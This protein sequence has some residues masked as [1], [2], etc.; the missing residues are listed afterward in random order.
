MA[1]LAPEAN[2]DLVGQERAA[3][4]LLQ[5]LRSN[6]LPHGWLLAGPRGVG[7]ATLAYRF[8]R[9][10]LRP[11]D[12][13]LDTL[14]LAP[15]HPLFRQ[16]AQRAHPDLKVIEPPRDARTGRLRSEIGVDA[17]RS[18]TASLHTTAAQ[19]GRR[20]VIVDGA[21]ALNRNAANALLKPLEEPP[22]GAVMLLITQ[23]SGRVAPT[24][25]SRVATL[26]LARLDAP[27]LAR[28]LARQAPGLDEPR[29]AALTALAQGSAGTALELAAGPALDL[30]AELLTALA[31][32]E[33]DRLVLHDLVQRLAAHADRSGFGAAVELLQIL[34]QRV[35]ASATGRLGP[36]IFDCEAALLGHLAARRPLDRWAGL[37]EKVGR[38]VGRTES[39]NL[40]RTHVLLLVLAEIASLRP[41]ADR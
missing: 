2:P 14:D 37:W 3:G 22:Q 38:L 11:D 29:R 33:V 20:V 27:A 35:V 18:V 6:R 16:V 25:R 23:D 21:E 17:I 12:P 9:R 7:K 41:P 28:I 31:C 1:I 34:L 19:G 30:Y 40:D 39:L 24:I 26:R 15:D 4:I 36:P 32:P 8:A 13:A 5:A 10:L